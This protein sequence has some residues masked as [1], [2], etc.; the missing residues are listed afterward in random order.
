MKKILRVGIIGAGLIGN[1]RADAISKIPGSKIV[2]FADVNF[3][4]AQAAAKKYNAEVCATWQKLVTRLDINAIVVAVPNVF[5]ARIAI[6]ALNHKK[7]VLCEKPFGINPKESRAILVAAKKNKRLVKAG[8]NHRFHPAIAR[9]KKLFDAGA[10]GKLVFL[11]ARYGHG[12]RRG[13]EKEWRMDPKI[14]GGGHLLDQGAHI[15]DLMRWFAG[16]FDEVYGVCDATV[17]SP[18]VED[19][20]FAIMKNKNVSASFHVSA[21]NWGNIFSFEIFGDQGYLV[22]EGLGRRYGIET[23]KFGKRKMKFGD[24]D[25][26]AEKFEST[27]DVS[28]ENEWKNFADAIRDGAKLSGDGIDGLRANEII[29]GVYRSSKTGREIYLQLT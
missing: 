6:A 10:I 1:K 2:A 29:E 14:A 8:F 5:A 26:H 12:G 7:H 18:N 9:A 23:L 20:A 3:S 11:R 27:I 25:L 13:M 4:Q 15:A 17:W 22:I 19:N 16:E 24:V 21:T 28:W